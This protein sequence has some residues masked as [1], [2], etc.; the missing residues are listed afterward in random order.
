MAALFYP[1]REMPA[2]AQRHSRRRLPATL[3]GAFSVKNVCTV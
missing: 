3:T 1:V 2:S